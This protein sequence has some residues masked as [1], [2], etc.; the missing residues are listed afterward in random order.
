MKWT[1]IEGNGF[2]L[3]GGSMFGN[4]PKELWKQWLIPNERNLIPL[5]CRTLLVETDDGRNVLFETG[6]GTFFE[7]KLRE[8]YGIYE[9]EH[10][11]IKNLAF[12][13]IKEADI[14]QI[15]LS[16]LHFDHAGGLLSAYEEGPLRLL[17]PNARYYI[18]REHWQRARQP[19]MRERASFIP[20]LHR[21]L[22]ASERLV[23]IDDTEHPDLDFGIRFTLSHGHTVGLLIPCLS[24]ENGPLALVSDLIPGLPWL[25]SA[26]STG[27][28][29]YAE[30]LIEEKAKYLEDLYSQ[31]GKLFFTHDPYTSFVSLTKNEK[32]KICVKESFFSI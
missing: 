32:G 3:D 27:Y 31:K 2:Q 8:R 7:P 30:L 22:E 18:G 11:L 12:H 6:V 23:L 15:V 29:R 21:L 4:A 16:H 24:T 20:E 28:D 19:H 9:S 26:I 1:A 25:N 10:M 14:D 13:G 17:F 5:A